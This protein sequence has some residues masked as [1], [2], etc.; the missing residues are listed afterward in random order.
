MPASALVGAAANLVTVGIAEKN[1]HK[2]TF[3][4]FLGYGVPVAVGSMVLASIYIL[5]RYYLVC[6]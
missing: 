3:G 6:R 1:G 4:Q 5:V 2:V